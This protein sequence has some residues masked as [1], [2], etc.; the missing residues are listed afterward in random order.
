[1]MKYPSLMGAIILTLL[2]A[3]GDQPTTNRGPGTV[4]MAVRLQ[5]IAAS[6]D[7]KENPYASTARLDALKASE[8]PADARARLQFTALLA[9][10]LLHAG[11]T[12][13]AIEHFRQ[14]LDQV[15]QYR[16]GMPTSFALAVRDLLAISYLRLGHEDNCVPPHATPRCSAPTSAS[17]VRA[18]ERGPRAAV[19]EYRLLLQAEPDNHTARW[20]LNLAYMALGEYPNGVPAQWQI[21]LEAFA[22]DYDIARFPDV[23][24][25]LGLD[26]LGQ[27]GGSIVDDFDGDG[28]VDIMTS[29][30]GLNDQLRYFRNGADGSFTERTSEAGLVGLVGGLNLVHADYDNDA[31]LDVFVLR[32]AWLREGH[33]NS[34]LRNNGDG[35]FE[36]VTEEAGLLWPELP[37]QTASWGDYNNDGWIDLYVGNESPVRTRNPA[38]LFRNNGDGTFTDVARDAGADVVGFIKA[39]VWG[40]VENDGKLDFYVSRLG[41]PN[42][43]LRNN[44]PD[45]L[46]RWTFTD[47]TEA[48]GVAEPTESFPAWF[49]DY[50]NDGWQDIF[51]TGRLGS[52]GDVA[53]EYL[54]LPHHAELP[55]LYRNNGDGTFSDVT[56]AARLNRIMLAMGANFGDLDNDGYLDFYVGTGDPDFRALMPN[57]M[58]RNAA[59][60]FFQD[61]TTSGGFGHLQ[62]GHGVAFGDLDNDGDQDIYVTLGAA[63]EGDRSYNALFEN[64]GHG[65]QWI[66]LKLEGVRSNRAGIGARIQITVETDQG[67]RDIYRTVTSGGSFGASSLQQE[68]G[69]GQA[70]A[71]RALT[72]TWPATGETDVYTNVPMNQI[73]ALREGDPILTR[74]VLKRLSFSNR[75]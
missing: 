16:D 52:S 46:G 38:Q 9:Q 39:V 43:L 72:V 63:Y 56:V 50:D 33:A 21:P 53:A 22:S 32:G 30:R 67:R 57:R 7:P 71:I 6:V 48:A 36:D 4:R 10:E 68:I 37:T 70:K 23:A 34:L 54:G 58:F 47:I 29:S 73:Y 5:Q 64:P 13:E 19:Q 26:V 60:K 45:S 35:T 12:E 55:R 59:G 51:V 18:I 14:V 42:V 40:D 44:G 69:L 74:V 66:T 1:M 25:E 28:Y 3:C 15:Q 20:L 17:D 61:V 2:A 11:R 31:D 24:A 65:N 62:K 8:P 41:D 75:R 49:W 27:A